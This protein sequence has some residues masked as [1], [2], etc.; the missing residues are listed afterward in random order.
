MPSP[1]GLL[2]GRGLLEGLGMELGVLIGAVLALLQ[3]S[4]EWG[5]AA[6]GTHGG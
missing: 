2:P 4:W 1:P 3:R 6:S 5:K